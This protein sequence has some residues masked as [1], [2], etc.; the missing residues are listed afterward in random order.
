ML[1]KSN[2]NYEAIL[3]WHPEMI[4]VSESPVTWQGFLIISDSLYPAD[5]IRCSRVKVKL[6]VPNYPLLHEARVSFGK[7]IA[8]L[9]NREFSREVNESIKSEETVLSFLTQLQ[10][11]IVNIGYIALLLFFVYIIDYIIIIYF[12]N[13]GSICI[14]VAKLVGQSTLNLRKIFYKI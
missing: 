14:Q 7:H 8:F 2:C 1:T 5:K 12:V 11:L 9:R 3:H 10:L 4:R 6:V 13:R